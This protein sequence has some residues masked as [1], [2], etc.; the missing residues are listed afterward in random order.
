MK[1]LTP[2]G[3]DQTKHDTAYTIRETIRVS[4]L[5]KKLREGWLRWFRDMWNVGRKDVLGR[6][7]G[8]CRRSSRAERGKTEKEVE[9]LCLGGDGGSEG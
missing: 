1:M 3:E 6:G 8:G 7:C 5:Y 4:E 9:E 2:S